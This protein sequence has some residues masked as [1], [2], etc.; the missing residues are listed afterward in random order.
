MSTTA[1]P[2]AM[3]EVTPRPPVL[4]APPRRR[5][6]RVLADSLRMALV[7]ALLVA[8]FGTAS[9]GFFSFRTFSAIAAQIPALLVASVGM[10]YVLMLGA[11]DLS[12]G[13]VLAFSGA[14]LGV[15][16]G[17][18]GLPLPLALVGCVA[19]GAALGALNG[20][21]IV[22]FRLPSFIVT[23]G[24]LE[25]ARGGTYLLTHSQTQYLGLRIERV[26]DAH[27][28]GIPAVFVFAL[29]IVALGQVVLSRTVFGRYVVATGTNEEVVR[30]TGIDARKIKIAA[31]ALSGALAAV[32]AV[33][34]TA[35][36]SAADP[37]AGIGFEL[38]AIAAVV[39]G[40]TSLMGGRGS[41]VG[42]LFGVAVIAVL[43]TGLAQMGAEEPVKRVMTGV[44]IVLAVIVD[45]LRNRGRS[46]GGVVR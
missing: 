23:L 42:T 33:L 46:A 43:E 37:N 26:A 6:P 32:A 8:T 44:V 28:L 36:L 20:L 29:L 10:T 38:Q 41:V 16:M 7:L 25:V 17:R 15:L 31:F 21:I 5:L 4:P 22:R 13:S 39:V 24:M 14:A 45:N 40:G 3:S 9:E 35:R 27:L 18:Q 2:A 19:T 30:L 12:I 34:R 11:I 1:A